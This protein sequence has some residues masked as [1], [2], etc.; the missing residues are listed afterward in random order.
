V[1][2]EWFVSVLQYFHKNTQNTRKTQNIETHWNTQK[3]HNTLVYCGRFQRAKNRDCIAQNT[4]HKTTADHLQNTAKHRK[5]LA[6][7]SQKKICEITSQNTLQNAR[8]TP[9]NVTKRS[10]YSRNT[11][12]SREFGI[13]SQNI[14]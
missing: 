2:C 3:N 5:T 6:K 11:Y 1:F 12:C 8:K 14:R 13:F 7:Q 9:K 4:F 10:Q